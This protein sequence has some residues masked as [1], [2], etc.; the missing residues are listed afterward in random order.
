MC[1][2]IPMRITERREFD[3]TTELNGMRRNVALMLTPE[4][5]EGDY[6]L[7][8]AGYAITIIDEEE[9]ERTLA[10]I[11]E[12]TGVATALSEDGAAAEEPTR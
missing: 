8:H 10:L 11:E 2:A 4:A 6:V 7:I 1:L 9:A 5:K 3:G 12:Y